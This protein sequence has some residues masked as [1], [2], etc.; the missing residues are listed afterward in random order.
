MGSIRLS[1][2][3][4]SARSLISPLFA[5]IVFFGHFTELGFVGTSDEHISIAQYLR[6]G[7]TS[8]TISAVIVTG[9]QEVSL[10]DV[11][12]QINFCAKVSLPVLGVI[13]NMSGFVCRKCG[14]ETMIFAATTGGAEALAKQF[15]I[16]FLGR[17]PL[18]PVIARCCDEGRSIL[19]EFPNSESAKRFAQITDGKLFAKSKITDSRCVFLCPNDQ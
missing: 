1:R 19:N 5:A 6:S 8:G 2:Y 13:E 10:V 3:R 17:I 11:R 4:H 14:T 16:P 12:K 9:P 15:N 18:D 7:S